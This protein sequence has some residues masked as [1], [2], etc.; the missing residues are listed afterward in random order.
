MFQLKWFREIVE[1]CHTTET[2]DAYKWLKVLDMEWT[3]KAPEACEIT[4]ALIDNTDYVW[5]GM[6]TETP[7]IIS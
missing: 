6:D 7:E 4:E 1:A 5:G 3:K 2:L